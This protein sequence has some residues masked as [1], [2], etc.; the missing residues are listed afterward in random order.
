MRVQKRA[1]LKAEIK[2]WQAQR[3]LS[4]DDNKKAAY[5]ALIAMNTAQ[6]CDCESAFITPGRARSSASVVGYERAVILKP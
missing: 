2:D 4:T 6:L 1:S 5:T 3:V